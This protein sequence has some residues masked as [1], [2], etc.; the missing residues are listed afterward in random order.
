MISLCYGCKKALG[1]GCGVGEFSHDFY[2]KPVDCYLHFFKQS[3]CGHGRT[4]C[5]GK[6][7]EFLGIHVVAGGRV[8]KLKVLPSE[9]L[10]CDSFH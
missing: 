1:L 3:Q 7:H 6:E 4:F 9:P 8:D 2:A 5:Y 10:K